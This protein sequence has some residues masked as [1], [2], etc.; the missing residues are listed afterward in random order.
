MALGGRQREQLRER[1]AW[2]AHRKNPVAGRQ[3]AHAGTDGLD[4][5]GPALAWN[6]GQ[7][8]PRLMLAGNQQQVDVVGRSGMHLD[9]NLARPGHRI[10]RIA[11]ARILD[12][13]E[14]G[15]D[16]G[17]HGLFLNGNSRSGD[18]DGDSHQS[19][20]LCRVE[21]VGTGSDGHPHRALSTLTR[22]G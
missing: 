7:W 2:L 6:V 9:Q 10:R 22:T 18:L 8:R 13:S 17:A 15:D 5:P 20:Q 19:P 12:G 3:A 14:L 1:A 16:N 4:D 21:P 11:K